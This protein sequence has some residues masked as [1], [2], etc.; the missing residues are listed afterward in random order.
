[1]STNIL[2]YTHGIREYKQV[3]L[4]FL[5]KLWRRELSASSTGVRSA[6]VPMS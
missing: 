1:M 6:A 3:S 5:I 4:L 2:Y